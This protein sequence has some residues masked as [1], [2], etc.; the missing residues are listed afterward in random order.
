VWY[1]LIENTLVASNVYEN[2][3]QNP[4]YEG[5]WV[6]KLDKL[7]DLK[8]HHNLGQPTN[9]EPKEASRMSHRHCIVLWEN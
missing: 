4:I 7:G 5:I 6:P 3:E 1:G 2:K 8:V 9:Q